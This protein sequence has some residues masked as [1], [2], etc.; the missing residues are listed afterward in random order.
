MHHG[1]LAADRHG[2]LVLL[3]GFPTLNIILT[4]FIFVCIS[5][6]IH[7]LTQ[8]L[9]TYAVPPNDWKLSVRNLILFIVV[10]IPIGRSDGM[11]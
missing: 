11:I 7:R 6:E 3:P 9:V 4:S 1:W 10:L 8:I 2:V 5:H